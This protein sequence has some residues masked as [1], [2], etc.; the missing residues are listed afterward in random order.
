M[1]VALPLHPPLVGVRGSYRPSRVRIGREPGIASLLRFA[2]SVEQGSCGVHN[3]GGVVVR[4]P[5][6]ILL[7]RLSCTPV[8]IYAPAPDPHVTRFV[9]KQSTMASHHVSGVVVVELGMAAIL[10]GRTG[11][12]REHLDT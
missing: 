11:F 7:F 12:H 2:F 9:R 1:R 3:R 10:R 6:N 5:P 4:H 8:A